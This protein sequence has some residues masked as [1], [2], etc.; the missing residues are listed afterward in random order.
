MPEGVRSDAPRV[1]AV[2][3]PRTWTSDK[4]NLACGSLRSWVTRMLWIPEDARDDFDAHIQPPARESISAENEVACH[5]RARRQ[6]LALAATISRLQAVNSAVRRPGPTVGL[7]PF[8][9][10]E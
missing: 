1:E 5:H 9:L 7:Q 4:T 8:T 3:W 2:A 10:G 6:L